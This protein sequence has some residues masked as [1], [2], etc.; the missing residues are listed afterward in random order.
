MVFN[1]QEADS[2][3]AG[4]EVNKTFSYFRITGTRETVPQQ[5]TGLDP[6]AAAVAENQ[7]SNQTQGSETTCQQ[8]RYTNECQE[9]RTPRV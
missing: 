8:W 1:N 5:G 3:M 7:V 9:N 4:A 2:M 6:D